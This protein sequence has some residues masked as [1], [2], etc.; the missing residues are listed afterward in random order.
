MSAEGAITNPKAAV[1]DLLGS[2]FWETGRPSARP[3]AREVAIFADGIE[4]GAACTVVGATTKNLVEALVERSSAVTVLDFSAGVAAALREAIRPERCTIRVH[5][6]TQP[7][8]DDLR[9][10]QRYVLSDR[11]VNRFS[12]EEAIAGVRGMLDLLAPG[13]EIRASVKLG[14]YPMDER[15][16]ALGRERGCLP[17]FYDEERR[18]IDFRASGDVLRDALLPHGDIEPNLLLAW[19]RGRGKEQRFSDEAVRQVFADAR[20]GRRTLR[21][22]SSERL[23]DAPLTR[24]YVARAETGA[25]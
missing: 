1:W 3:S 23:P 5:D 25:A 12:E 24:I 13:G 4:A 19:Y 22:V 18:V 10:T 6:I 14:L 7:A 15:M 17:R 21:L 8:P 20:V 9:E 16:I 2:R 11:L